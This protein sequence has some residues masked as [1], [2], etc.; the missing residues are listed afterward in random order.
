VFVDLR[1]TDPAAPVNAN[2]SENPATRLA[3]DEVIA[4]MQ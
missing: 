3:E 2:Q 4:Q 1:S